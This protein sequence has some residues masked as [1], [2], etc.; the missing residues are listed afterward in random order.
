MSINQVS[1]MGGK[2][3]LRQFDNSVQRMVE[4]VYPEHVWHP[5]KHRFVTMGFWSKVSNQV[6]YVEWLARVLGIGP[7]KEG[8]YK[9]TNSIVREHNGAAL[10]HHYNFSL[11]S[12]LSTVYPAHQWVAWKF[13]QVPDGFWDNTDN[14]R[15]YLLWLGKQLG[16][17]QMSDW[18]AIKKKDYLKYHGG[19]LLGRFYGNSPSAMVQ[20]VFSDHL[21]NADYFTGRSRKKGRA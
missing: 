7:D 11:P 17:T 19:Y 6:A 14:H 12:A 21:W 15:A 18:Y 16:Y 1:Q 8:W 4:G 2:E 13:S 5:W 10:L 20:Q 9:V 3:L